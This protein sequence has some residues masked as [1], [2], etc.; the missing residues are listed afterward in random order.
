MQACGCNNKS[1]VKHIE[2]WLRAARQVCSAV[3]ASDAKSDMHARCASATID[4]IEIV[5]S[6][7]KQNRCGVL[8]QAAVEAIMLP[9]ILDEKQR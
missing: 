7:G 1:A 4:L 9:G 5:H 3:P 6:Y 8:S 2:N